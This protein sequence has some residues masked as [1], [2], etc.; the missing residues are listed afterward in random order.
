MQY[1][2][3]EAAIGGLEHTA[4]RSYKVLVLKSHV[5]QDWPELRIICI[6]AH[7]VTSYP[8]QSVAKMLKRRKFVYGLIGG[9]YGGCSHIIYEMTLNYRNNTF[10]C[11]SSDAILFR[12]N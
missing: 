11:I 1:C 9:V 6:I 3:S 10:Q 4:A 7:D 5:M 8:G 2:V 12:H